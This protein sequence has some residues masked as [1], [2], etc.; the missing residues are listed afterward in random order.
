IVLN[1]GRY[2]RHENEVVQQFRNTMTEEH[3]L[4]HTGILFIHG[5]QLEGQTIEGFVKKQCSGEKLLDPIDK[6][7]KEISCYKNELLQK[8]EKEIQEEMNFFL[9]N[10]SPEWKQEKAKGFFFSLL[11]KKNFW[12]TRDEFYCVGI[13]VETAVV[14]ALLKAF[15]KGGG[16]DTLTSKPA[17]GTAAAVEAVNTGGEA[18]EFENVADREA[19][20]V[21]GA[22]AATGPVILP[23]VLRATALTGAIGREITGWKDAEEVD[24]VYDTMKKAAKVNY[25]YRKVMVEK[26][27]EFYK[28]QA[29]MLKTNTETVLQFIR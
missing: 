9:D 8:M 4:K 29:I 21:R 22:R 14:V 3:V 10:L 13:G 2:T 15:S 12:N 16:R 5:E 1:V 7:V 19:A 20:E 25:E 24:S 26:I 28:T 18:A 23:G 17:G 27:Q 6:M 11:K